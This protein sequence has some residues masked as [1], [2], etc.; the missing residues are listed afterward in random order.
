MKEIVL[1]SVLFCLTACGSPTSE[2]EDIAAI[3][4][5]ME[6]Q[7]KAWS[8]Y[9]L[10]TFMGTYV[11]SDSLTFFSGGSV[12]QGWQSTLA[13]YIKRYP[14]EEHTGTLDFTLHNIT[15]INEDAYWV[16]GEYHLTRNI[17][18]AKGT[19]MVIFKRIYGEWKIVADSSC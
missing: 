7:K 10:E 11:N 14:T 12:T 19:F 8:S 15:R 16:M 17:G 3:K 5:V 9:D 2:Q 13:N 1:M 18:N 6:V 4:S